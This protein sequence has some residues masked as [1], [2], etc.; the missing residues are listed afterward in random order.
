MIGSKR[1]HSIFLCGI[2]FFPVC[3]PAKES[4]SPEKAAA[5]TA[6]RHRLRA[7]FSMRGISYPPAHLA[8]L[9]LK[10][11]KLLEVR[12]KTSAGWVKVK[13]YPVLKASGKAGPKL[14]EGDRQV[15]E[16]IYRI[17]NL[18]PNSKFYLSLRLNFPNT[19]DLKHADAEKR[20]EPGSDI[21]IHGKEESTGCL[22]MGDP[23]MDELYTM[24]MDAGMPNTTVVIAPNDLRKRGPVTNMRAA[25][26]WTADLY[27]EIKSSLV[28]FSKMEKVR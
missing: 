17:T 21:Y 23:A 24:V 6:A 22:A 27:K 28:K 18:N 9:A 1:V 2:L 16:G 13:A 25:P 15:P 8:F 4:M 19:F 10:H 12:A 7:M 5:I 3:A 26:G 11:E 20:K 14:K